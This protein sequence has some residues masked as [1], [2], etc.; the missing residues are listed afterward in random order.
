MLVHWSSGRFPE[1]STPPH[2]EYHGFVYHEALS[3]CRFIARVR[4]EGLRDGAAL[5]PFNALQIIPF[6]NI[7]G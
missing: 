7:G 3:G 6:R 5:S 1:F 2:A 4:I